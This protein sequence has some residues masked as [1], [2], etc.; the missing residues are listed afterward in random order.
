MKVE[1]LGSPHNQHGNVYFV[2]ENEGR[3]GQNSLYLQQFSLLP[4]R[5]RK[6]DL[7]EVEILLYA[8]MLPYWNDQ[9]SMNAV[10][11]NYPST[12]YYKLPLPGSSRFPL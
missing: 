3:G 2:W 11:C 4:P 6:S 10:Y 12:T 5:Q 9:A 1:A 7:L 8:V